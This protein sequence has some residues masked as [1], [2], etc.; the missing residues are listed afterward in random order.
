MKIITLEEHFQLAEIKLAQTDS[1]FPPL[2]PPKRIQKVLVRFLAE[3]FL[4][5]LKKRPLVPMEVLVV[6]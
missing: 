3:E 1:L 4:P 6:C 2:R 5:L